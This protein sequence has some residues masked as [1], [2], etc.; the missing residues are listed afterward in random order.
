MSR[1]F[2][3]QSLRQALAATV[4]PQRRGEASDVTPLALALGSEENN[5]A[6]D[7]GVLAACQD[8]AARWWAALL[9]AQAHWAQDEREQA[10][11]LYQVAASYPVSKLK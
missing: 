10:A 11:K 8:A 2:R 5:T 6:V 4:R 3:E 9:A 1:Y 7:V